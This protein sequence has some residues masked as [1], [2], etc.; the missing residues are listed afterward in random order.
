MRKM[1]PNGYNWLNIV[2]QLLEWLDEAHNGEMWLEIDLNS[3]KCFWLKPPH[4]I[5]T[6][7]IM[8]VK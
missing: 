6:L 7:L 8:G 5:R 3:I 4:K 1:C 2:I